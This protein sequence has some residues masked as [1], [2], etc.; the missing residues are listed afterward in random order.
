M[1]SWRG[2]EHRA[3]VLQR[4]ERHPGAGASGRGHRLEGRASGGHRRELGTDEEGV[5]EQQEHRDPQGQGM[6][7]AD[8]SP[9]GSPSASVGGWL[10]GF[11]DEPQPVDPPP[12]HPRD[13]DRP[14]GQGQL[15]AD[16]GDAAQHGHDEPA[17]GLV[18][19]A[20]RD[21]GAELVADLV[22]P[23]EAR[24]QPGPVGHLVPVG[25]RPVVLVADLADDLLH[26]VL[27]GRPL[28][29]SRRTRRPPPPSAGRARAAGAAAGRGGWSRAPSPAARKFDLERRILAAHVD[30][31]EVGKVDAIGDLEPECLAIEVDASAPLP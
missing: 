5:P 10:V 3:Q 4:V 30:Q 8:A 15:V 9:D 2:R 22:G 13:A 24:E 17:D 19:R 21:H 11:R 28:R 6:A 18:G 20:V 7:H 29:R 1:P 14:A 27:E 31:R 12:V 26:D 23:P 25:L 16:D